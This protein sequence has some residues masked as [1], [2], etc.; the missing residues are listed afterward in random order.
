[1]A[2]KMARSFEDLRASGKRWRRK[3]LPSTITVTSGVGREAAPGAENIT[4]TKL[5]S[6]TFLRRD[7][8]GA[9]QGVTKVRRF[10]KGKVDHLCVRVF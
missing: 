5:E 10:V 6:V 7:K 8:A 3:L 2:A 4:T 9:K 1:M